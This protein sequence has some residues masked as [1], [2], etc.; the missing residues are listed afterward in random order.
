MDSTFFREEFHAGN[1][2]LTENTA[3]SKKKQ[4]KKNKEKPQHNSY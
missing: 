2:H 4:K 3:Q 1:R